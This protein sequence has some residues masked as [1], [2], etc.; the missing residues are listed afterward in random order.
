MPGIGKANVKFN[1][2]Q[3]DYHTGIKMP[4][5]DNTAKKTELKGYHLVPEQ[6]KHLLYVR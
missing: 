3:H 6:M 4:T 5:G 2:F 1:L